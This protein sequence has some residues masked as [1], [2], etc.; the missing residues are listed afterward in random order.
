MT[1]AALLPVVGKV[2]DKL[3]PDPEKANEAKYKL[4]EMQQKGDLAAL[5]AD[6]RLALGQME[7]NKE[8]AKHTSWYVA[9][10]R[11]FVGWICGV[12]LVYE[13][14]AQPLLGFV[15]GIYA[16]PEPPSID[17]VGLLTLLGGMLGLGSFR[18]YE[19]FKGVEKNR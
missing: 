11:P 18:T 15:A 12:G 5:D 17:S 16:W 19:K 2:I 6:V 9:G 8:E 7:I 3:F 10:W 1:I 13:F 4:L 14:L